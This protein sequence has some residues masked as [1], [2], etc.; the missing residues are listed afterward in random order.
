[1]LLPLL[2]V[3]IIKLWVQR[4]GPRLLSTTVTGN[5][6][7]MMAFCYLLGLDVLNCL[8]HRNDSRSSAYTTVNFFEPNM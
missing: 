6:W 2:S 7:K 3:L 1:M 8:S 5:T 4:G